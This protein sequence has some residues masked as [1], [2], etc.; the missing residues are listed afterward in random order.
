MKLTNKKR[1]ALCLAGCYLALSL[2]GC[3]TPTTPDTEGRTLTEARQA[4]REAGMEEQDIR[5]VGEKGDPNRLFVCDH[6]PD[7]VAVTKPA[8]LD[9]ARECAVDSDGED[10]KASKKSGKSASKKS[11]SKSSAKKGRS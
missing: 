1:A 5:I 9:V 7:G 11:A 2:S 6:D 10:A 8:T 4:L 3:G